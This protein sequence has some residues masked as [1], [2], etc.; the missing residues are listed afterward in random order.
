MHSQHAVPAYF[1]RTMIQAKNISYLNL[2]QYTDD[3]NIGFRVSE[4]D[5]DSWQS[6]P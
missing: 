6:L 3:K 4:S 1:S 2:A 5:Q